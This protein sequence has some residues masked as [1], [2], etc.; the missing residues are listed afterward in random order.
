M[1]HTEILW[2]P[3]FTHQ[4]VQDRVFGSGHIIIADVG[5]RGGIQ[6]QW[7]LLG[8]QARFIGFEPDETECRRINAASSPEKVL[9]YPLALDRIPRRRLIYRRAQNRAGDGLYKVKVWFSHRFGIATPD[10]IAEELPLPPRDAP[11]TPADVLEIETT[12]LEHA[13]RASNLPRP[14][15][16]KVDVEGAELDVLRGAESLLGPDGL[17]GIEAEL[18]FMPANE[19]PLFFEACEYLAKRG[20]MVFN[21]SLHRMSRKVLPQPL[22][23]D[24]R[25]QHGKPLLF[26][27]T[28]RGQIDY[29]DI[30]FFRDLLSDNFV[31]KPGN[32][33]DLLRILT[34]A[35]FFEIYNLPDCAAELLVFYRKQLA[36]IVDVDKLLDQ[37]VPAEMGEMG[38]REYLDRYRQGSG[39]IRMPWAI[40]AH[41]RRLLRA[42]RRK[43]SAYYHRQFPFATQLKR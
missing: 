15:F 37:L 6:Q 21:I 26:G 17:I 27:S 3:R 2:N 20:Y 43:A 14:D 12:T 11:E 23:G 35:S 5:M 34:A 36:Q 31:P 29:A 9:C 16:L 32:R 7:T 8:D 1:H 41:G 42:L 24:H 30:V 18:R 22:A 38:Y 25:D 13:L 28:T 39:R 33:E 4:L 40:A 10:E 19:A